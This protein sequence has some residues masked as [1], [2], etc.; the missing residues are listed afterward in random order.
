AEAVT[1]VRAEIGDAGAAAASVAA[2]GSGSGAAAA[3][4]G[5]EVVDATADAGPDLAAGAARGGGAG[6]QGGAEPGAPVRPRRAARLRRLALAVVVV[7]VITLAGAGWLSAKVRLADT[8]DR[9]AATRADLAAREDDLA[10]ATRRESL[11]QASIEQVQASIDLA[12]ADRAWFEAMAANI[13]LE[14]AAVEAEQAEVATAQ[15][16][17][18]ANSADALTCFGGVSA[19]VDANRSGDDQA[20]A[21]ALRSSAGACSRTLAFATGARFPYDFADPFVLTAPDAYYGYSTNAGAGD[22]QVI[23]STDLVTWELVGNALPTLPAWASPGATWAP[24]V[25]ARGGGYVVYYTVREAASQRQCISRAVA[26]KPTGP[27][28]DDSIGPLVC[29]RELGGS[30]DPSPFVDADGRAYLLWKAEGTGGPPQTIWSQEL[31]ADGL[32]LT[33]EAHAL[34]SADRSFE[35]GVVEAPSLVRQG[36]AYYL[37]YA[38]ADWNSRRYTTAFATCAGPAGPCS[39]PADGRILSSGTHLA[40]PGGVEVFRDRDGA[41]WAAFHAFSEP[42]VGYPASRYLYLARVR[43]VGEGLVIDAAT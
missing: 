40:G 31:T 27:F 39:K 30:I 28:R 2:T 37:V 41:L 17:V 33:G 15:M 10:N 25:L 21:D 12:V 1:G 4:P 5:A 26:T 16:L 36:N 20:S 24:A 18:A 23:R 11:V 32:A 9:L 8:R 22:V 29:Q 34:V 42:N 6:P 7:V 43:V 3:E 14:I 13:Q 35:R 19:A 38:A